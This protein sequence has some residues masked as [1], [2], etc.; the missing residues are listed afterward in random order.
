MNF[1]YKIGFLGAGNMAKAIV[2]GLV[3]AQVVS[4]HEIIVSDPYGDIGV[5]GVETVKDSMIVFK[6]CE[7]VFLAIK[8]QVFYSITQE[9]AENLKSDYLISIMAGVTMD[10]LKKAAGKAKVIRVMPNLPCKL[11]KG[12]SALCYDGLNAEAETFVNAIFSSVGRVVRINEEQ[13]HAVTS[14]SGSG[15]AY[16]YM[17]IK[18]MIEAGINGGLDFETART[19][20]LA[21]FEGATAMVD[22]SNE[23]IDN[24]IDSVCSKGGTTIEAVESFKKDDIYHIIDR[25]I[26]KCRNRSEELGKN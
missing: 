6:Q 12:M 13:F 18:G 14:I 10:C 16:V 7:Y 8:P 20:T 17:F 15:P 26:E 25:A 24:L 19:L 5:D 1:T 21:T 23:P 2:N 3:R 11:A 22:A 4:P 9:I